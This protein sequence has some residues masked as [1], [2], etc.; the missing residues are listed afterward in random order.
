[1][2]S[3]EGM[4]TIDGEDHPVS[5][6]SAA[7]IPSNSEHA[8]RNTGDGPLGVVYAFAVGSFDEIE[9]RFTARQ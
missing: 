1:M 7:H 3:G 9:Y 2:L 4:L 6:G 8:M 5:A